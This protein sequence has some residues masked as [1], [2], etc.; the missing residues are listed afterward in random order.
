ML[1]KSVVRII[2][3]VGCS[4]LRKYVFLQ[5]TELSLFTRVDLANFHALQRNRSE[6]NVAQHQV[7]RY[8]AINGTAVIHLEPYSTS[9]MPTF[10]TIIIS[11]S[12]SNLQLKRVP[13]I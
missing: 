10:E 7:W 3:F 8:D 5:L 6:R 11:C 13:A 4:K 1:A 2:N 12:L 9:T